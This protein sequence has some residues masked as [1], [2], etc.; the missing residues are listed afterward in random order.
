MEVNSYTLWIEAEN[1][2]EGEWDEFDSNTDVIV[3]FPD[4]S[5]WIA[6]FFTYKNINTLVEKNIISGECLHGRYYWS[7]DL[8]LIQKCSR[9]LI[10]EVVNY[11]KEFKRRAAD[12]QIQALKSFREA[13]SSL[14][15]AP[16]SLL[17]GLEAYE[18]YK[19]AKSNFKKISDKI[20]TELQSISED[21]SK[22]IVFKSVLEIYYL[23]GV[24]CVENNP[25]IIE[26]AKIR[27]LLGEPPGSNSVT[28]GDEVIWEALL[29]TVQE[30]LII[31]TNDKSFKNNIIVLKDE[32][33]EITGRNLFMV[34]KLS[35]AIKM[36]GGLPSK[37]LEDYENKVKLMTY[38]EVKEKVKQKGYNYFPGDIHIIIFS[39]G[40]DKIVN[41]SEE[42]LKQLLNDMK[43]DEIRNIRDSEN[44]ELKE[45]ILRL[46]IYDL[47]QNSV[48][49]SYVRRIR[50][51]AM[52]LI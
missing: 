52:T 24:T 21:R 20:I 31:I 26:R 13:H 22:D 37:S 36:F 6:S 25:A 40:P 27:H 8:I 44:V 39:I 41:M 19:L 35:E 4:A 43:S 14:S 18:E 28:I 2:A 47:E 33:N 46:E 10:E 49:D 5:K 48:T 16:T 1:W 50:K 9:N 3:H 45:A 23:K 29:D 15:H 12:V 7:S 51:E 30:D 38:A 32:F 11:L 17:Q 42:T 34:E